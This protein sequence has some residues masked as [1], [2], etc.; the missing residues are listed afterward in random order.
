[1]FKLGFYTNDELQEY[2]YSNIYNVEQN[3][4]YKRLVIGLNKRH[5]DTILDFTSVLSEPFYLLYVLHTP[6]TGNESGRYQSGAFA[7]EEISKLLNQFKNFF[8]NDARHDMWIH[9]PKTNTTI[10]YDRHNCI[11]LYGFTKEHMHIIEKKDLKKEPV[12]IPIPHVHNYNTEYDSAESKFL[13]EYQWNITPL[14][15]EDRQ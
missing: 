9:S 14:H 1:M 10:V 3:S 8:E 15:D 2:Y 11:Y 12:N 7:F 13:N 4:N 6:R 5:I